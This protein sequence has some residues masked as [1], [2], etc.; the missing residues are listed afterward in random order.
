MPDPLLPELDQRA[1]AATGDIGPWSE[2]W[3]PE[4]ELETAFVDLIAT[5]RRLQ[6]LSAGSRPTVAAARQAARLAAAAAD[7]LSAY[8][9]GEPDQIAGKQP[10]IPGRAQCMIPAVHYE[11][12]EADAVRAHVTFS[13]FYL[14]GGGAVHGGALTLIFDKVL[15]RLAGAG[16]RPRSRTAYLHVNYRNIAPLDRELQLRA[17]V[18]RIEGRKIWTSAALHDGATLLSDAESLFVTLKPGQP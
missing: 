6:D 3:R 9:V 8:Q 18:D 15:G 16:G 4:P 1:A 2:A 13:R 11:Q 12:A 14:G 17:S 10:H 5:L 7:R